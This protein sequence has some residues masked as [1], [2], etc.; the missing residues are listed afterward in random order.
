MAKEL[1][2]RGIRVNAVSPGA[3][4]R[5]ENPRPENLIALFV[6]MTALGRIGQAPD[7]AAAVRFLGSDAAAFITGEILNVNGGYSL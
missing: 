1:G 3:T 4:E 6:E 2:A 5:P 7:I